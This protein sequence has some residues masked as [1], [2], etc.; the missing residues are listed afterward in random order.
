MSSPDV[1]RKV[2]I[3]LNLIYLQLRNSSVS[4]LCS[5]NVSDWEPSHEQDGVLT[6]G[7]R[8]LCVRVRPR[9]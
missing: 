7:H 1:L 4:D 2:K 6:Q 5:C 9:A 3:I 8:S